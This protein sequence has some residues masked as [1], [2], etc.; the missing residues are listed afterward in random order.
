MKISLIWLNRNKSDINQIDVDSHFYA[1]H[2][3]L[4]HLMQSIFSRNDAVTESRMLAP[5]VGFSRG[6]GF[7]STQLNLRCAHS[8]SQA[9]RG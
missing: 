7:V 2:S 9:Q 5:G 1:C 6:L 8:S 4:L 3:Y